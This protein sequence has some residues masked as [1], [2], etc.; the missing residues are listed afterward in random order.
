MTK[1]MEDNLWYRGK[2]PIIDKY[3]S[4]QKQ[5][6]DVVAG[7]GILYRPG[8]L[9]E[10][11]TSIELNAKTGLSDLNYQIVTAAIERELAQTGH[12]YDIAVK[13]AMIAW[14]LEKATA[15]T[16]L[17][18]DFAD[19]KKVRDMDDQELDR[20]EITTNL[21]K[22]VLMAAKTA[23]DIDMEELRQEMTTVDQSTF[24]AED[25]LLAA[26]LAAGRKKLEV[27]PYIE[28]VLEKQQLI[29]DAEEDNADRKTALITEKEILNDKREDLIDARELI[30]DAIVTLIAAKQALVV[31][32]E[33]L[34]DAKELVSGQET[35]NVGYLN[36]YIQSLTGLDAEKQ[37]LITAKKALIPYIHNK[38]SALIA[39][40]AELDAWVIVKDAIAT[41]KEQ[42]SSEMEL[43]VDKKGDIIDAKVDLNDL[44]LDLQE[45][46]INL[47]IAR[48]TGKSDLM[49]QNIKNAALML[50]ER[51]TSFNAK[52][53]RESALTSGQID[54]D[55]YDAQ[56]GFETTSEVNDI[57][58]D[59][60]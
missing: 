51:E 9:G 30:A 15:L 12:D 11:I 7:R 28:T 48:M 50:A 16:T 42:I 27:I 45:A 58:F 59:A 10:A 38:S 13:E 53:T 39:Y 6:E 37:S 43:R 24:P 29:I 2:R 52:I 22:L 36:L 34:I 47:E 19:N 57:E 18:Q 44:K 20:L 5:A 49:T 33:G 21:R 41:I 54:L 23:I 26:R 32:R 3:L 1:A 46:K 35:L 56:V 8:F 4:E 31:K 55:L 25:A 60:E 40:T 14:E 17:Q